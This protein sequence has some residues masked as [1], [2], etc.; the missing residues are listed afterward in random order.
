MN[1]KTNWATTSNYSVSHLIIDL[2]SSKSI[3]CAIVSLRLDYANTRLYRLES[4]TISID[5]R[6]LK[7]ALPA[8]SNPP[9]LLLCRARYL[10][11]F[12]GCLFDSKSLSLAWLVYGMKPPPPICHLSTTLTLQHDHFELL[13]TH[14]CWIISELHLLLVTSD[15]LDHEFG[16]LPDDIK[17]A[18]S[19]SSFRSKLKTHLFTLT[20]H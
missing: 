20:H 19:F 3:A 11:P 16:T 9:T 5:Y 8:L 1:H 6:E 15:L 18:P 17:L 7:I 14:S 10:P 12:I 13:H 4:P 2:E